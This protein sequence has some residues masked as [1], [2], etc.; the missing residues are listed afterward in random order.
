MADRPSFFTELKRRN[1]LRAAV[2]YAGAAWAFGQGL[3]QFSPALNLPDYATRWFL[4]AAVIGF[5]FWLAFAWLY[6]FTPQGF[7][8]DEDVAEN[9]P[10][11]QS[12]SRKLDVAIIGVLIVAVVLLGSGYFVRR[13]APAAAQTAKLAAFHPPA[14]TI[15]VLPFANLDND[16]KQQYFSDGITEEL[17]NALGQNTALRVIAWDTAS[18]YRNSQQAGTDIGKALNVASV[19]T[20][21]IERQGDNVRVIVELVNAANGYQLWSNHYDD[22]LANI[23]QV[24]DKISG[25]IAAA[26]KVKFADASAPRRVNPKAYDLVQKAREL[27]NRA[28]SAAPFEQA[29]PLLEQAIALDPDYAEAHALLAHVWFDLTQVSTLPLKDALSKVRAEANRALGIDPDNVTAIVGLALADQAEGKRA[30][31]KAGYQ[32]ALELDPSNAA[33]HLDYATVLPPQ[34]SVAETFEAVQLDPGNAAAQNNLADDYLDFGDYARALP[35]AQAVLRLDPR[36]ADSA[37]TLAQTYA[38]LHRNAEAVKAFDL[39]KAETPLAKAL[40]AAGKLSFES[41]LDPARHAEA[42]AAVEA[43]GRRTDLD[44]YSLADVIQL[45]L[46]LG[47]KRSALALLPGFCAS[48]RVD[49]DDLGV[50]P[51]WLPLH[52]EPRFEALVKQNDTVSKRAAAA[53]A[54][55]SS[56]PTASQ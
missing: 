3:S 16:P 29:R 20:G 12:N 25:A 31:A 1:V 49:C 9:A 33:A 53:S 34:Q 18:K 43:L 38:L 13:A 48:F 17:T 47:E 55:A 15:V 36:S 23:F 37:L 52:G 50:N 11:R 26:L 46:V 40:I 14:D 39:V 10:A 30:Q 42:L 4:I 8:R 44:P 7:K 21:K 28:R 56:S 32:R 19:L 45:D 35:P 22:Q 6:E 41:V 54:G 24:Q 5:P 51:V 27:V 2:L